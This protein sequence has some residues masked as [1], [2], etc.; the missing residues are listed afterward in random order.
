MTLH[1]TAELQIRGTLVA[2]LVVL[3]GVGVG[4]NKEKTSG[5]GGQSPNSV[6]ATMKGDKITLQDLDDVAGAQLFQVRKQALDQLIMERLIKNA[7]AKKSQTEEQFLKAEIDDKV[8][9]PSEEQIKEMFD[10]SAAQLPPGA[11]FDEYKGRIADFLTRPQKQEKAKAL[12][13]Q[14]K[15]EAEV[16]VVLSEPRK[17]VEAK[18]PARGPEKAK[19][20]IVEFSDFECPFCSRAM[21]T[22]DKVMEAYP[23]KVRLVFR[24][25]PLEFHKKAPKA[26]EAALC[27]ND[28]GKFWEYH[29]QLFANQQKL[30][31][32]QLK[33]HATAVG[34]DAAKFSECLDGGKMASAVQTDMAAGKKLGINGT[35]AFFINGVMLSGAQ[36]I[37]E[38]KRIIDQEL[39]TN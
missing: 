1:T 29:N 20:T 38:F 25:F 36:P 28:Q 14:L 30:E 23:G 31:P 13:D 17:T 3:A 34:L 4:C 10:K 35:P 5:A 18:G 7:A 27:A 11:T 39:A 24:H 15:Q 2:L 22:V 16:K 9:P 21:E 8:S 12:F 33:E 26:A 19:V 6:V 32:E 37:D